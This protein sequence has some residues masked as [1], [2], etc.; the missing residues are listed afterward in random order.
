MGDWFQQKSFPV[1]MSFYMNLV[2]RSN[3]GEKE[4]TC[5]QPI[6]NHS[7]LIMLCL[8]GGFEERFG[9]ENEKADFP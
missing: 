6:H 2:W 3:V 7:C 4:C 8:V 9:K 1:S 5:F